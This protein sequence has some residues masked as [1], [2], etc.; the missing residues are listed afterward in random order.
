MGKIITFKP[1]F[2]VVDIVS[3]ASVAV[4]ILNLKKYLEK[5]SLTAYFKAILHYFG[6]NLPLGSTGD[7]C[8]ELK[9][10]FSIFYPSVKS[11][12]GERPNGKNQFIVGFPP[13][14]MNS[15]V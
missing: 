3:E 13:C 2:S 6:L 15:K 7:R 14:K 4:F 11:I 10:V 12:G 5:I 9:P 8:T 1:Y